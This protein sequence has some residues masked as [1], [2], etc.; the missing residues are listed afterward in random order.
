M[1]YLTLLTYLQSAL[2]PILIFIALLFFAMVRGRRAITSLILGFYFALLLSLKFPYY[3]AISEATKSFL[4]SSAISILVF[5]VFAALCTM[6]MD[7]LLFY[8]IDEAAFQS[9]GKKILLA[10]IATI[11]IM[12]YSY[13][14]LPITN[15]VDP[16]L[17]ASV[18]FEPPEYFFWWLIL[19]LA[20][21]FLV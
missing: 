2:T 12:L 16:G 8:R 1:D 10:S 6:L 17:P 3:Q 4:G 21:L 13:H 7:R 18:L 5:A 15:I 9:F 20:G 19:P 14:V 11:L